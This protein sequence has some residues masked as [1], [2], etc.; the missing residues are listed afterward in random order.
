[1][2]KSW[3]NPSTV[4]T[5]VKTMW[6]VLHLRY[7]YWCLLTNKQNISPPALWTALV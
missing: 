3:E 2:Y 7:W 4:N 6:I 5:E 1:M